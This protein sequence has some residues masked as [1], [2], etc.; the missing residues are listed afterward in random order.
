[1]PTFAASNCIINRICHRFGFK[2]S[3][4]FNYHPDCYL[5]CFKKQQDNAIIKIEL[6]N[7]AQSKWE[8][9]VITNDTYSNKK[10]IIL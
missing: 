1:M 8:M 2:R 4:K 6:I 3:E 5:V 9:I 10:S 7:D